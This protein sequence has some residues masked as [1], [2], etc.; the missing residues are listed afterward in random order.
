MSVYPSL[1]CESLWLSEK[2]PVSR[3]LSKFRRLSR[4]ERAS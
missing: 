2:V 4:E 1:P 3:R